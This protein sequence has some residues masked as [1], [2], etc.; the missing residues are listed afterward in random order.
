M[1]PKRKRLIRSLFATVLANGKR[2]SSP[3]FS[4]VISEGKQG[5]L[6]GKH[7]YAVIVSK[8]T[9][10]LSVTRHRIKRRVLAALRKCS[11]PPILIIFPRQS[12]NSVNYRD[13]EAELVGLLSKK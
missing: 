1:F 6:A 11:L 13:M 9:A 7:G 2:F 10:Q 4:V 12:A 8:K 5:I 3:N